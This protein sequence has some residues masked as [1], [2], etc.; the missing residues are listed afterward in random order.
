MVTE[1]MKRRDI[2]KTWTVN[3]QRVSPI[4]TAGAILEPGHW[5]EL[6]HFYY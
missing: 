4:H 1:N 2:K 6:I 3:A 5:Q